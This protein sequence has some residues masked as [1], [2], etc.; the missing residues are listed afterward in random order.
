MINVTGYELGTAKS[1]RAGKEVAAR[2]VNLGHVADV[3]VAGLKNLVGIA[4]A[5]GTVVRDTV[6]VTL[7]ALRGRY[8]H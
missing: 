3:P 1:M 8:D 7:D 4:C 5:V 2:S 6:Y